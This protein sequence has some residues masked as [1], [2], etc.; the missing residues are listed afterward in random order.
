MNETSLKVF[1]AVCET[2]SFTKAAS[3]LF[4]TQ[5]AVSRHVQALEHLYGVDLFERRGRSIELT[6]NGEILRAKARELFALH[7]EVEALFDDI[8]E[9][10]RGKIT[11]A[12]SAT[13]ATYLLPPAI[14]AFR[15]QFPGVTIEQLSGNTHE[16]KQMV[17]NGD[18]DI[19]FGGG[20]GVDS[21]QLIRAL[22]HRERLVIVTRTDSDI[23]KIKEVTPED[24]LGYQFV[25][26]EKGTQIRLYVRELFKNT[27]MQEPGVVVS[28]VA[29]AKRFAQVEGY[30]TALPYSAVKREVEDGRLATLN[31]KGFDFTMDFNAFV[32]ASHRLG[33]AGQAFLQHLLNRA[34]FNE[35]RS[36]KKLLNLGE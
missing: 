11:I 6:P 36:L 30:L 25:W 2:G 7:A 10:R 3:E 4:I 33:T 26:R 32:S 35:A 15:E 27:P 8:V 1:M 24:M 28:R 22:V 12:A 5:P 9:L 17:G 13:I 19:G 23:C 18:A 16:V 29:T 34:D 31:V 14:A 20:A 21:R